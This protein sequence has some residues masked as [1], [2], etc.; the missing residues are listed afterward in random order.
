M[1][2]TKALEGVQNLK[3]I[4]REVNNTFITLAPK[5]EKSKMFIDY[6][7]LALC[8]TLYKLF[9]KIMGMRIQKL[10][11]NLISKEQTLCV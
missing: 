6:S 3:K 4:L 2:V 9:T 8:N 1:E 11:P 5:K 10:L 7:S